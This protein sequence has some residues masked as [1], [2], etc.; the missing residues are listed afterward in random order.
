MGL[1]AFGGG[2]KG[3]GG[4]LLFFEE[5]RRGG[6]EDDCTQKKLL[7]SRGRSGSKR[8]PSSL[9]GIL[10]VQGRWYVHGSDKKGEGRR[11]GEKSCSL[12]HQ[13]ARPL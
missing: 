7:A 1:G 13:P 10:E 4:E 11:R 3:I 6:G 9:P 5:K 12:T 2:G 8:G